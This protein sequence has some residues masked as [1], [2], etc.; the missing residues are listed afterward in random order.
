MPDLELADV[1]RSL[2]ANLKDKLGGTI[3]DANADAI[4]YAAA[5][6]YR[7]DVEPRLWEE[8][9]A[10]QLLDSLGVPRSGAFVPY[11]LSDRLL[12][13]RRN[14]AEDPYRTQ[15]HD[16]LDELGVPRADEAGREHGLRA[17]LTLLLESFEEGV[18]AP[19]R[20][21]A[22]G[23]VGD[24][25]VNSNGDGDH[26]GPEGTDETEAEG[27]TDTVGGPELVDALEA[28]QRAVGPEEQDDPIVS[29]PP[30]PPTDLIGLGSLLGSVQ[31]ELAEV[32]QAVE[33]LREEVR[34]A[35]AV[36]QAAAERERSPAPKMEVP[37]EPISPQEPTRVL[38]PIAAAPPDGSDGSGDDE[39]ILDEAL[40]LEP[41]RRP[42]RVV[43]L[44]LLIVVIGVLLAAGITA[45]IV[46]GW[47]EMKSNLLDSIGTPFPRSAAGTAW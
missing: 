4:A 40:A 23:D 25:S 47:D 46:I 11:S 8:K 20:N 28:I 3:T 21:P 33:S 38:P 1:Y 41:S 39:A 7:R 32:R 10:H 17:R 30:P 27:E 35:L 18:P 22:P 42:R 2:V 15:A 44:V 31:Q 16:L 12:L 34:D 13:L 5:E 6:V 36:F 37:P 9:S 19:L 43:R 14:E 26:G 29:S 24:A 45:A